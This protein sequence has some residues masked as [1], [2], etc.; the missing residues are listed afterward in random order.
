MHLHTTVD[1]AG[2][3]YSFSLTE[4]S[5]DVASSSS[6]IGGERIIALAIAIRCFCPP[7]SLIPF[8]PTSVNKPLGNSAMNSEQLAA[9]HA[10]LTISSVASGRPFPQPIP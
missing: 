6:R 7:L 8:S 9:S 5:A 2:G 3:T 1:C 10:A 4:S